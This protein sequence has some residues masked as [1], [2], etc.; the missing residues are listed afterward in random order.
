MCSTDPDSF[1]PRLLLYIL[2]STSHNNQLCSHL[3]TIALRCLTCPSPFSWLLILCSA[4]L[5][6]HPL[7]NPFPQAAKQ[8]DGRQGG[9]GRHLVRGRKGLDA[10]G[11]ELPGKPCSGDRLW[12]GR[13]KK[14]AV[15]RK[16]RRV[17]KLL[18]RPFRMWRRLRHDGVLLLRR[19]LFS[20]AR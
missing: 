12:L 13:A 2:V 20:G 10:P 8:D 6:A 4:P 16:V 11:G 3:T 14:V 17:E 1:D 15:C 7:F 9:E 18:L 19:T 5:C